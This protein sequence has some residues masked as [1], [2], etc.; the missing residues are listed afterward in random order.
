MS[1][2]LPTLK[3]IPFLTVWQRFAP[4]AQSLPPP[5]PPPPPPPP[6]PPGSPGFAVPLI[7]SP[8][9]MEPL[10]ELQPVTAPALA[11]G[12]PVEPSVPPCGKMFCP[13]IGTRHVVP[14]H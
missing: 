11:P 3:A 14:A 6:F 8:L 7:H 2:P 10:G 12:E 5:A 1:L 13:E 9:L 4:V